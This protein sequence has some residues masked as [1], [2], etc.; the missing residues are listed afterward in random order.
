[1]PNTSQAIDIP[2]VEP[3]SISSP[4]LIVFAAVSFGVIIA[5]GIAMQWLMPDDPMPLY[6]AGGAIVFA[7]AM[8]TFLRWLI[9]RTGIAVVGDNLVVRTGVGRRAVALVNLRTHGL[10]VID[11]TQHAELDTAGKRWSATMPNLKTG[12]F[13]LRNNDR[14]M[15]VVTDPR[16][17]SYLRSEA[18]AL[19]LLLSLKNPDQ[20]R[21]IVER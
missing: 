11:L 21:E 9:L 19:T 4:W 6:F 13:R 14:A 3:A 16:R 12:L 8:S 2:I 17:V 5:A 7:I 10:R 20:L 1:M 15:V 18:D